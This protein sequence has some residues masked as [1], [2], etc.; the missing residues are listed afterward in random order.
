MKLLP[1][2]IDRRKH[3]APVVKEKGKPPRIYKPKR[4]S[5]G[6]TRGITLHQTACWL[7]ERPERYD[8]IGAHFAITRRATI[9]W[10]ADLDRVVFHG[11][12][13]NNQ[14]VGIEIDGLFAGVDGDPRTVW[15]DPSTPHREEAMV[16]TGPQ[17]QAARDLIGWIK[18]TVVENGGEL[19]VLVAHRQ[20]S[21]TRRNDPGSAVWR[22][23]ALPM[24]LLHGLSDG[25]PGFKIG[26][27]RPIPELWDAS[28][29]GV[30][31]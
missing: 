20:S 16:P 19:E 3:H 27:G 28:R 23:V 17:L 24:M 13:F 21:E 5:W 30:P 15:D 29:K 22:E 18:A 31:Y 7:G 25:G 12:G 26:G 1:N 4:R 6:A 11:N 9:L 10:M 2:M 14:C 8:H